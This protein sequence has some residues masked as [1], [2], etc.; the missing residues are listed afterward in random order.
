MARRHALDQFPAAA[1]DAAAA[2]PAEPAA[3]AAEPAADA[4]EPAAA[5]PGSEHARCA[6]LLAAVPAGSREALV[7]T[8]FCGQTITETAGLLGTSTARV[9]AQVRGALTSLRGGDR[10]GDRAPV[11]ATGEPHHVT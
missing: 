9:A 2:D 1:A 11:V 6:R 10:G 7:L 3:D 5:D 8:Y 4:V